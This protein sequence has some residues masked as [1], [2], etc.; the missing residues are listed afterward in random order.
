MREETEEP[1]SHYFPGGEKNEPVIR[2]VICD[3]YHVNEDR[4]KKIYNHM[5][6]YAHGLAVLY[7]QGRCV[8]TDED[9]SAMLSEVFLALTRGEKI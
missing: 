7:A 2:G 8:F 5:A 6:V 4:A 9:V 1:F 3:S